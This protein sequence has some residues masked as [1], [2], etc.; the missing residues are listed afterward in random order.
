[1]SNLNAS[2]FVFEIHVFTKITLFYVCETT[3]KKDWKF[4]AA[5]KIHFIWMDEW[6]ILSS[7]GS[8]NTHNMKFECFSFSILNRMNIEKWIEFNISFDF[9]LFR[10]FVNRPNRYKRKNIFIYVFLGRARKCR[11]LMDKKY[12]TELLLP[13]ILCGS[14]VRHHAYTSVPY[15]PFSV[16]MNYRYYFFQYI[17]SLFRRKCWNITC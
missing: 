4:N 16:D 10:N 14:V 1:M 8:S 6:L 11:K 9:T 12:Y 2:N 17:F 15:F 5:L 13:W 3:E 7:N